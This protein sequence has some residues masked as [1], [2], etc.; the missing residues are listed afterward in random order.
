MTQLIRLGVYDAETYNN[1]GVLQQRLMRTTE[2][3]TSYE[4]AIKID[5]N[6]SVAYSN[7]G[8]ALREQKKLENALNYYNQAI[9]L[10]PR[11]LDAYS[12]R[13]NTLLE[14]SQNED[15][16]RDYC[17]CLAINPDFSQARWAIPFTH[18]PFVFKKK[19]NL[20]N[21]RSQFS[22]ALNDLENWLD[23]HQNEETFEAVKTNLPF[24]LAY[25][26]LNNKELLEKYGAVV[27]KVMRPWQEKNVQTRNIETSSKINI[28]IFVSNQKNN[29]SVWNAI[30]SGWIN[31]LDSN[32]FNIK[33]FNLGDPS[34]IK[35]EE[36]RY[37]LTAVID[38]QFSLADW[39]KR[40]LE[41]NIEV[42]IY[43]EIGMH[44]MTTQLAA[45][46]LATIQIASWGHP[47]TTGLKTIDYYLSAELFEPD[48]SENFYTE[49][50]IKLPNLGCA[51]KKLPIK[52]TT[53]D[54]NALGLNED[55]AIFLCPGA[56]FKY[57]PEFDWVLAKIAKRMVCCKFVFFA[58]QKTWTSILV[59]RLSNAFSEEG[60]SIEDFIVFAPW[61]SP[62]QFYG[63]MSKAHVFLDT[64]GF[65][66][67]NTAIQAIDCN[68]P[69][70]TR[71]G[72][73]MRVD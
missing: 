46:R 17:N 54:L 36:S 27:N 28:G 42:L 9:N 45:L 49:E 66:G 4:H 35:I 13:A 70:V 41:N 16:Y 11:F 72:K 39:T 23:D 47:E 22:N 63:L 26:E 34:D 60:L 6:F 73:F 51:Y 10:N 64:I 65:S 7:L 67:F 3:I 19:E 55:E 44:P 29:Y 20:E 57:A 48:N 25:Q 8:N 5:P 1:R 56:Y 37:R 53:I 31:N 24:L 59:Q 14:L 62:D 50:L 12:N 30:T 61:L 71:E 43:P 33:I 18:I 69:I 2:A 58:Q 15:A 68:L 40:V 52:P 32:L 21:L 38:N